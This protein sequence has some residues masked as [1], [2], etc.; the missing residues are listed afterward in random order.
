MC[1]GNAY[2]GFEFVQFASQADGS[3]FATKDEALAA[4]KA[5]MNTWFCN[6]GM[7]APPGMFTLRSLNREHTTTYPE[8]SSK[9]KAAHVKNMIHYMAELTHRLV[10]TS[11]RSQTRATLFW[12]L[13]RF[14]HVLDTAGR[15][16][17]EREISEAQEAGFLFLACYGKLAQ[18]ALARDEK[19][20]KLKPKLHYLAHHFLDLSNSW[21]PR[22]THAFL[23]EDFLGKVVRLGQRCHRTTISLRFLQRYILLQA[24]RWQRRR[25]RGV[26]KL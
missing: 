25:R 6:R 12:A 15:W 8:L 24:T 7:S 17:T 20:W 21:N 26:F 16:L 14:V 9:F 10:G 4:T 19:L 13:S 11:F 5:D 2:S 22:F 18:L 1:G 23:E 3:P